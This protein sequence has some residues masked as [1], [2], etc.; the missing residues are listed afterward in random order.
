MWFMEKVLRSKERPN[1]K[2]DHHVLFKA[3]KMII[4]VQSNWCASKLSPTDAAVQFHLRCSL[5]IA[6]HLWWI[7]S[8]SLWKFVSMKVHTANVEQ[9]EWKKKE[10]EPV[11]KS[12]A[13]YRSL[14]SIQFIIRS[15]LLSKCDCW[16]WS[17]IHESLPVKN[18]ISRARYSSRCVSHDQP[19]C[20]HS[21]AYL[22][23]T[24]KRAK[25]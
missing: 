9:T 24:Q 16:G 10:T 5:A 25:H 13:I 23:A 19:E 11:S 8:H 1:K 12:S 7:C 22:S 2:K 21:F 6:M 4:H 20:T 17:K 15:Y 18:N 3:H 14:K